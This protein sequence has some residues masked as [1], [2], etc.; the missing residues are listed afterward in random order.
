MRA[1]SDTDADPLERWA[2]WRDA[3]NS[4]VWDTHVGG[5]PVCML[6][7]ESRTVA[8]RGFVPADGPPAW[9][10]GTL[11][12][13]ASRKTA[14]AVNATSGNRPLVVLANLSGF[15]GSPESMRRWQL[16]YGAEIGRAVVNF[17]GPIVFV[18]I[19]RY[20]GGAFVVFSKKLNKAME[21]AAVEGSYASVIGGAPAAAT[22]FAREVKTRTGKDPRVVSLQESIAA[23]SGGEASAM[24][25]ELVRLTEDVRSEKLGEVAAEFDAVHT[26]Q[27]ALSV[28]SVDRIIPAAD[29]RP[30][31]VD[32]L[33]RGM[34]RALAE[35]D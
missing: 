33:E 16:E 27:R 21:I 24:R 5:I 1:V 30:Y 3:E 13:Q 35:A 7:L 8:R 12:P 14:R 25:A 18:V 9:T 29:L 2:R 19:S 31:V 15:D 28:G 4:V 22:V 23:A 11:F 6:G 34:A 26:I 20:H 17:D 32:A 10:S